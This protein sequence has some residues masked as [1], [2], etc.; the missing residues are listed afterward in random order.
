VGDGSLDIGR[1][2]GDVDRMRMSI[3]PDRRRRKKESV[4]KASLQAYDIGLLCSPHRRPL[5]SAE[6]ANS[7]SLGC[8]GLQIPANP[9][10]EAT[11][12]RRRRDIRAVGGDDDHYHTLANPA[13][14]EKPGE[15]AP[16]R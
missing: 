5:G 13:K 14:G 15:R 16:G 9:P 8:A 10:M 6:G 12:A 2:L 7:V 3:R 1:L 4:Q 11:E